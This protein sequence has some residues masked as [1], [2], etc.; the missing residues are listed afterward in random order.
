[1]AEKSF[2]LLNQRSNAKISTSQMHDRIPYNSKGC[3]WYNPSEITLDSKIRDI[4]EYLKERLFVLDDIEQIA[5]YFQYNRINA[6]EATLFLSRLLFPTY[7]FDICEKII[8]GEND[9]ILIQKLNRI[10][11]FELN[12]KK[13]Y[14]FLKANY[15]IP[16][17]EWLNN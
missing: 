5:Y 9:T 17:I 15:K 11:L 12:L 16:E 14:T 2:I 13:V 10:E 4:S 7:Y 6:E 8:E 1:M 3:E